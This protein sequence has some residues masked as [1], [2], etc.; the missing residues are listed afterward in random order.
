MF[1]G[2]WND[3]RLIQ[4]DVEFYALA[5]S[6][7]GFAVRQEVCRVFVSVRSKFSIGKNAP[8]RIGFSLRLAAMS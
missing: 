5:R 4:N 6:I 7:V 2:T 3:R 1:V 8:L